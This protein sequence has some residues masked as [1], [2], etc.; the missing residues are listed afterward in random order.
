[1]NRL[2]Q[3]FLDHQQPIIGGWVSID[4]TFSAEVLGHAG[5]DC[6]TVDMQHGLTS[7]AESLQMI[8]AISSTPAI[9]MARV[10]WNDP[11]SIMRLLDFG[12]M[13][14]ICPMINTEEDAK[15]FVHA[16]RYAPRGN[17]SFGPICAAI[18]YPNYFQNAND[19]V[20]TLAMIET[21]QAYDEL[22]KILAVNEL[23]GIFVGPNDLGVDFG[24]GPMTALDQEDQ[25][26]DQLIEHIAEMTKKYNKFT[27]IFCGNAKV[28]KKRIA[29]GY[30]YVIP[31]HDNIYLKNA[32]Q[33][34][35]DEMQQP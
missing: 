20:I 34:A 9:P 22:E 28:A 24:Y 19:S 17:R 1:M 18:K 2:K 13:G 5:F 15:D 31:G 8:Q 25:E 10:R 3:K 23:D 7:D 27:G 21:K 12:A 29:Q 16:C 35:I 6:V 32:A 33:Q 11:A 26:F 4:S 30:Q 14:I